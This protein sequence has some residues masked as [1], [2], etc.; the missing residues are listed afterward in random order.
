MFIINPYRFGGNP[1]KGSLEFDGSTDYLA[2]SDANF[3]AIT[4]NKFAIALS[5]RLDTLSGTAPIYSKMN[6]VTSGQR[7][8]RFAI[9]GS[10]NLQIEL[11]SDGAARPAIFNTA[12]NEVVTGTWYAFL[13]HYD[14][15]QGTPANR[16]TVWKNNSLVTNTSAINPPTSIFDGNLDVTI[17]ADSNA[18]Q[19]V[20]GLIYSAAFFDN[21][22]PAAV[23]VF[24]GSAGKLKDLS[25]IAGL[26]SLL[27]GSTA[28]DDYLLTDWTNAG[29][30]TTSAT[31]P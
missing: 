5:F 14:G 17:G 25:G 3:G 6:V 30:V 2:I 22:L 4:A 1:V 7:S 24:D 27:T 19:F 8:F 20:D 21:A 31:V 10:G 16:I 23:D 9:G 13:I 29:T 26:K 28:T 12:I 11:S 15:A 18:S